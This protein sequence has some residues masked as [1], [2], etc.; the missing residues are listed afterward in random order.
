MI[1]LRKIA[2][3]AVVT[4]VAFGATFTL[5]RSGG[6]RH[7]PGPAAGTRP[8]TL[9]VPRSVDAG[10]LALPGVVPDLAVPRPAPPA[11]T[12]PAPPPQPVSRPPAPTPP[13]PTPQPK[14][15]KPEPTVTVIGG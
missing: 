10:V 11:P 1:G 15:A 3:L 9:G 7:A 2:V 4:I 5:G 6:E 12:A 13:P 14:P 8:V